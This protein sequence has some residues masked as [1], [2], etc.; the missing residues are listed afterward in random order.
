MA[1]LPSYVA[2]GILLPL[3]LMAFRILQGIAIG[4]QYSGLVVIL[5]EAESTTVC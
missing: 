2:I 3:L 5:V 1:L 4:G